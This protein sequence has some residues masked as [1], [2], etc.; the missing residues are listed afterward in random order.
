MRFKKDAWLFSKVPV[1][2]HRDAVE[3]TVILSLFLFS[4]PMFIA[5]RAGSAKRKTIVFQEPQ[6]VLLYIR[7]SLQKKNSISQPG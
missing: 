4:F 2:V 7:L 5:I 1:S 6:C 3:F